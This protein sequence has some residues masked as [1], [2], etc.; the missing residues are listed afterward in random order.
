MSRENTVSSEI[1]VNVFLDIDWSIG[2]AQSQF[3][4][5]IRFS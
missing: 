1:V 2:L 3:N 4:F 5:K